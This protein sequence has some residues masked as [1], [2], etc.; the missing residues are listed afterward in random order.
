MPERPFTLDS[1]LS[2]R[3][4]IEGEAGRGGMAT[5]Y[6]AWD[7]RHERFVAIKV[8]LPELASSIG[9]DRF[10]REIS[11]AAQLRH[12]HIVPLYDS[13]ETGGQ[14]YFVMPFL[15]GE[16]LRGRLQREGR[17]PVDEASRLAREVAD[18][19]SYAHGKGVVH[20]DIKPENILIES[21]HAVVSDFGIARAVE[22]A[23]GSTLTGTGTVVGTPAYMSPEQAAGDEPIEGRSDVYSL[24]CV[25]FEMLTG[26]P[27]FDGTTARA[28]IAA[29]LSEPPAPLGRVRP[30]VP[31]ALAVA[32]AGA[33]AKDPAHRT[34]SAEAFRTAL[35]SGERPRV[36]STWN[37]WLAGTVAAI[38]VIIAGGTLLLRRSPSGLDPNLV[39]VAPFSTLDPRLGLW[40]EGLVDLLSRNLDGA[41]PLK[42]VAPTLVIRRWHG[43]ADKASGAELARATGARL[44]V[45][46][47]LLATGADSARLT[48]ILFDAGK[49]EA[50]AEID[51]RDDA[52]HVDRLADSLTLRILKALGQTKGLE[53]FRSTSSSFHSLAAL[54]AFLQGEQWFRKTSWDSAEAAFRRAAALDTLSPL[55]PFRLSHTLAWARGLE[56]GEWQALALRA[57]S[58]NH[59]LSPRDSLQVAFDSVVADV[60]RAFPMMSSAELHRVHALAS[61]LTV[62]YPSDAESWY[63]RGDAAYHFG[64]MY[65]ANPS[66]ALAD[67]DHAIALDSS[68]APAYIHPI[69]IAY[70]R[71]GPAGA[72]RYLAPYLARGSTG[73]FESGLTLVARLVDSAADPAAAARLLAA[74]PLDHLGIAWGTMDRGDDSAAWDVAIARAQITR[75][76]PGTPRSPLL[77]F[78][79][80][81]HGQ[82]GEGTKELLASGA[83]AVP[84]QFLFDGA[85]L[86]AG[87]DPAL[88]TIFARWLELPGPPKLFVIGALASFAARGDSAALLR[89]LHLFESPGP[90]PGDQWRDLARYG[91]ASTRA[92]LTLLRRDTVTAMRL[93]ASLPDSLF[94]LAYTERL[95]LAALYSARHEDQKAEGL[96]ERLL[97]DIPTPAQVVWRL[98]HARTEERLGRRD[99][100]RRDYRYVANMW[101]HAD[102]DLRSYLT[103]ARAGLARLSGESSGR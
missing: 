47:N 67:F 17:L 50:L 75:T 8:L 87:A 32:V 46:G 22:A 93:F 5:V 64:S 96:L 68:F 89:S 31:P 53:A 54:K 92:Y 85:L 90:L 12:P 91:V 1:D 42:T 77:A 65:G 103:E 16:S 2:S 49:N 3:Y 20:R 102:P 63:D 26:K 86:H 7:L 57:G 52:N 100:A 101:A 14:L 18:A 55:P 74:E 60:S 34:P 36:R 33:L 73:T 84:N 30:D 72:R 13:G 83:T 56:D 27:P 94:P 78:S 76:P 45:F 99:D 98:L 40:R 62:H 44:V 43:E 35:D 25:L 59:G 21:G 95:T 4:R 28:I 10:L 61:E 9:R 23:G 37:R 71:D 38:I 80:I 97:T 19:L 29:H 24:G 39:A 69:A 70:E 81:D 15:E 82:L 48:A 79:L 88:D 6:R 51:L 41:G 11:I 58:L 66:G